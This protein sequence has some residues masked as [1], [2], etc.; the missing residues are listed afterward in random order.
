M[1]AAPPPSPPAVVRAWSAALNRGDDEA[2]AALFAP[3]ARI[4]QGAVN[5]R[6]TPRLTLLFTIGLPCG[7]RIVALRR[8]GA[9][10]TATFRLTHRPG[11]TC[12]GPGQKAAA[13]FTIDRRGLIVRWQ[14]VPVPPT[15]PPARA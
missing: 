8:R 5:F 13:V 3:H 10:V 14:Q 2:A 12:D 4:V 9:R 1:V 7:G 6:S 15:Q 11:H